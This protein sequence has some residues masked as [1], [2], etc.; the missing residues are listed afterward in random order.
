MHDLDNLFISI[1]GLIGAGKSTLAQA[2]GQLLNIPTYHEPVA[3]NKY[4][5]DFYADMYKFSFPMQIHLLTKRFKQQQQI[6]WTDQGAVQDRTIYEDPIFAS[7]LMQAGYMS[8]KDYHTYLDLFSS[9]SNFMKRPNLIVHLDVTPEE[10]LARINNR[11]RECEKGITLDYLRALHNAYNEFIKEISKTI[12]VIVIKY[13][14]FYDVNDIANSINEK[15][16]EMQS[17]KVINF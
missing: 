3:D 4:L 16:R 14:K 13:D 15:Y 9:M 8:E 12:P 10:A 6:I 7:M 5:Q 17:I 2:L 11:G 1:S